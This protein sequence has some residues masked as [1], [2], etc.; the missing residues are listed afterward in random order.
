M[1]ASIV[2]GNYEQKKGFK[3]TETSSA[4]AHLQLFDQ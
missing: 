1:H 3:N 2:V 4:A